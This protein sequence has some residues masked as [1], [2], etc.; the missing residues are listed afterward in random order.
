MIYDTFLFNGEL[1]LLEIRLNILND[2]VDQFVIVEAATT[3]TMDPKE[4]YYEN[5]KEGLPHYCDIINK[6]DYFYKTHYAPHDIEVTEFSSGKTRRD[7]AYQLGI[8]FKILPKL[9]LEDGIHSAKMILPRC[10]IDMDNCKHLVD[11]LRHYHRKY[12]EK[13]KIF[14]SKPVHAWSSHAADAFR[15]LALSVNEVLTKSTAMPRATD[16]EYKIFSK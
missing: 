14:H 13:M 12:N 8:N 7:V 4:L 9:P 10:W 1:D 11:A 16:S 2:Y 6:K 15:Y 3:F 5:N